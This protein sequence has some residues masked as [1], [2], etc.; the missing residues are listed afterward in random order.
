MTVSAIFACD[1]NYG[2]GMNN[3]LPWQRHDDDMAWFR[4]TTMDNVIVMGSKTWSSIGSKPLPKR[5]NIV[6]TKNGVI[7]NPDMILS[8]SIISILGKLEHDHPNKEI[9]VIGGANIYQQALPYCDFIYMTKFKEA[10][11][12][13]TYIDDSMLIP[14]TQLSSEIKGNAEYVIM[15]R[16]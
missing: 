1:V 11:E 13:D 15:K 7:G 4:K 16:V 10:Y 6:I 8:G 14:F 2:I 12:C 9:F 5:K 3:D